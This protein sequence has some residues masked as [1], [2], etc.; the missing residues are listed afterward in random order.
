MT[1]ID[2]RMDP[3]RIFACM[4]AAAEAGLA[5]RVRYNK[6]EDG[7]S[8]TDFVEA[9]PFPATQALVT[10]SSISANGRMSTNARDSS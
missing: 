7:I 3:G 1:R 4:S 5:P 10:S 2:E 8:I 6:A 9:V